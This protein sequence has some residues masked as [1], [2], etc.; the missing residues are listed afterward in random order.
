MIS[1]MK[2]NVTESEYCFQ[3]IKTQQELEHMDY[4]KYKH[5]VNEIVSNT[6]DIHNK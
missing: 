4:N 2:D 6:K 5:F 3:S 1:M